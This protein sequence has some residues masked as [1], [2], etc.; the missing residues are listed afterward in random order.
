MAAEQ[1]ALDTYRRTLAAARRAQGEAAARSSDPGE[2]DV[3][4]DII[5]DLIASGDTVDADDVRRRVG[6]SGNVTGAAFSFLAKRGEIECVGFAV[7]KSPT[8]SGGTIRRWRRNDAEHERTTGL[9]Y[10]TGRSATNS[11]QEPTYARL[12]PKAREPRGQDPEG[13]AE[14]SDRA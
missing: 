9:R 7:S 4:V 11:N 3:V 6:A 2:F 12:V 10:E 8:R 5:R 14:L 13:S 1:L